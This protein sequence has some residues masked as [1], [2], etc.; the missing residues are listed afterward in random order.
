MTIISWF[1][2]TLTLDL[3]KV[4][5]SSLRSSRVDQRFRERGEFESHRFHAP[6]FPRLTKDVFSTIPACTVGCGATISTHRRED[7]YPIRIT[8]F[9]YERN[10]IFVVSSI[11]NVQIWVREL[12]LKLVLFFLLNN[13]FPLSFSEQSIQILYAVGQLQHR[14]LIDGR[15]RSSWNTKHLFFRLDSRAVRETS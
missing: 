8:A 1:Q 6:V 9:A 13:A 7:S 15:C 10:G 14:S 11:R 4:I 5:R 12:R 2:C 3:A